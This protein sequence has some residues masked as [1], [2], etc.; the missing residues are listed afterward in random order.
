MAYNP[1]CTDAQLD[2][3]YGKINVDADADADADANETKILARR[4]AARNAA[5]A[6]IYDRLRATPYSASFPILDSAGIVPLTLVDACVK[7]SGYWLST[8]RGVVDFDKDGN[9]LTILFADYLDALRTLEE[10]ASDKIRLDVI[11]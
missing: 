4:L 5:T 6:R 9:P 8:L 7:L 2:A 1:L 10:I 3:R 11:K